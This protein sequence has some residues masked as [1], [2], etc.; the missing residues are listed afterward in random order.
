MGCKRSRVRI[1]PP[2]PL[3]RMERGMDRVNVG[4]LGLGTV[5]SGVAELLLR[6]RAFLA[7]QAGVPIVLKKIVTRH[8]RRVRS[9]RVPDGMIS[10]RPADILEDPQIHLVV[11]LIGGVTTARKAVLA[12]IRA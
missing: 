11:E 4:L 3:E 2:R 1:S 8:P 5:G 9:V 7:R 6:R 10:G 12:A